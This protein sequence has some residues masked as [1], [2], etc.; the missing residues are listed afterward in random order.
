MPP[1]R[2]M[3]GQHIDEERAKMYT[4][5]F[6]NNESNVQGEL[7]AKIINQREY[8]PDKSYVYVLV[9]KFFSKDMYYPT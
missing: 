7:K 1:F 5:L 3:M 9:N 4:N 6:T 2:G 8:L